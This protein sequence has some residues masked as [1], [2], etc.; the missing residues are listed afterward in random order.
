MG[1][2]AIK[3]AHGIETVRL[4]P[5]EY[6][7]VSQSAMHACTT[8]IRAVIPAY[9]TKESFGDAD[10][11]YTGDLSLDPSWPTVKNGGVTSVGFP[12]ES[13]RYFQVDFI[14]T[15]PELFYFAIGYFSFNDLGN[16]IGRV[17]HRMG[18]K[19]GHDGLWLV[20]REGDHVY[21]DI[22]ITN[23]YVAALRFLGYDKRGQFH[24]M[25]DIFQYVT[26]SRYFSRDLFP[27]EHRN[28]K[29]RMRDSK[30]PTYNAFLRWLDEHPDIP[31]GAS[32][33]PRPDAVHRPNASWETVRQ[34]CTNF[35]GLSDKICVAQF[36]WI[37]NK[38]AKKIFNG[39]VVS[40]LTGLT[41]KE[42]GQFIAAFKD[43]IG[44]EFFS[45]WV[46]N[47]TNPENHIREF[48]VNHWQFKG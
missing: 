29:A 17:A 21:A 35:P 18:L 30:R 45:Y 42:L 44:H 12:I 13:N 32:A 16:L 43:H 28:T 25:E 36:T 7:A 4:L 41:G 5:S 22:R 20:L 27:L 19:F 40:N 39:Q 37:A 48:Y 6:E 46:F 31:D 33:I 34:L 15:T 11:L 24:T 26:T 3:T 23:D 2:K 1:G 8:G 38:D 9:T 14:K 47:S 10:I